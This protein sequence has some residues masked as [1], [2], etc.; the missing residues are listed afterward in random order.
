[1][2][3]VPS[4]RLR[5]LLFAWIET[6][7]ELFLHSIAFVRLQ[8]RRLLWMSKGA[9]SLWHYNLRAN[10]CLSGVFVEVPTWT[11]WTSH[12][13]FVYAA[14]SSTSSNRSLRT[15]QVLSW[16]TWRNSQFTILWEPSV[17]SILTVLRVSR[18]SVGAHIKHKTLLQVAVLCKSSEL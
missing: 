1:M 13:D 10:A 14:Q 9:K 12:F 3:V 2:F 6:S 7:S 4:T 8:T 15:L 18:I 17:S 11:C 5:Y 16:N